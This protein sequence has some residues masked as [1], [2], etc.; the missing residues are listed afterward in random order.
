MSKAGDIFENT[1]TG[2]FG[3]VRVGTEETNGELMVSDLR[4]H[5]GAAS[6]GPHIHANVDERFTAVTGKLGYLL[7]EE[8][9]ILNPGESME[10]P[11]GTVHDFW[12][13]ADKETRVIVEIRPAARFEMMAR[14]MVGLAR[15][16]KTGKKGMPNPL[17]MA[18]IDQ[19]FQD[20][21][22]VMNPPV[23]VQRILFGLLAPIARL[24]G[25]KAIYSHYQEMT[26]GT[27]AVEP[28]PEGIAIPEL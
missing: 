17:Q 18:L 5:P 16:G 15:E 6:I 13:A 3:Y 28:L 25:Y 14:T 2:E 27:T 22:Q 21:L 8:K 24:A 7:G 19:E 20:I 26:L 1:V 4:L 10:V 23:W 9:K 11:R 12:N